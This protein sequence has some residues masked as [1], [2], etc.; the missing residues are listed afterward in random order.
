MSERNQEAVGWVIQHPWQRKD[1]NDAWE[2]VLQSTYCGYLDSSP[3]RDTLYHILVAHAFSTEWTQ[4]NEP[5]ELPACRIEKASLEFPLHYTECIL[6]H[7]NDCNADHDQH[8][9][10]SWPIFWSITQCDFVARLPA[11]H[12]TGPS[13]QGYWFLVVVLSSF[14]W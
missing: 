4:W 14:A 8:S 3:S 12:T 1:T 13:R 10:W 5:Y 11:L 7:S 9:L 2:C 6:H